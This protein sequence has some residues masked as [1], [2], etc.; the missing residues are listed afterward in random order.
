MNTSLDPATLRLKPSPEQIQAAIS[1][2]ESFSPAPQILGRALLLIRDAQ[3]DVE[4][5]AGLIRGDPALAGEIIRLANS[6]YFGGEQRVQNVEYA[7]Q[8]IGFRE[9]RRL[10]TFAVS[11]I[12]TLEDLKSYCISAEDF[13]AESLFNGLFMEKLAEA[14]GAVD[15]GDAYTAGL[16]R[17]VGRL[18]INQSIETLGGG[19]YWVG[20]ESLTQWEMDTVGLTYAGAGGILLRRWRF[21]ESLIVG[22]EGQE[23]PAVLATPSWIASALFFISSVLPQDFDQPFNPVLGPIADSEFLHP[24]GLT[25]E[26]LDRIFA[27][28]CTAYRE[29]RQTLG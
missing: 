26:S 24:N 8:R 27:E 22:C 18:A 12:M 28:T 1:R 4:T 9:A 10:L 23:R 20:T 17:Y 21:P 3:C 15:S 25:A 16:L 11:R 7:L 6:A 2:I 13:W 19:A 5:V 14:T 29:I